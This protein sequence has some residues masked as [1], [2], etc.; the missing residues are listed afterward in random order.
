MN[1]ST[2]R[3]D[4][5]FDE[6]I[7]YLAQFICLKALGQEEADTALENDPKE[8]FTTQHLG[9]GADLMTLV[10]QLSFKNSGASH[11]KRTNGQERH[12]T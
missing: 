1:L 8:G 6:F 9:R 2:G 7:S 12:S 5:Y 10:R 11:R 3:I 4:V